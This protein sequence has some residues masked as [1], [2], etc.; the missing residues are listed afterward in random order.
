MDIKNRIIPC[1]SYDDAHA[2]MDFLCQAF[3]FEK[4]HAYETEDGKVAHAQLNYE[5]NG[6]MLGST[7][8][9]SEFSTKHI[10]QPKEVDGKETQAP[11]IIIDGDKIDAHY[12]NAKK[13]GA[14]IIMELEEQPYGGKNYTAVDPEGHIWNFGSYDPSEEAS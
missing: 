13:H 4:L 1:L 9:G 2:A 11:Y 14:K 8:T 12:E 7:N 10:V 6:I 5:G 3:G